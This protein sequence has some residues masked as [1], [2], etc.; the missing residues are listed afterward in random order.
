MCLEL[1]WV[2]DSEWSICSLGQWEMTY[3]KQNCR[4]LPPWLYH[5]GNSR[6]FRQEGLRHGNL[7]EKEMKRLVLILKICVYQ[8][9]VLHRL[10][11]MWWSLGCHWHGHHI[12]MPGKG[13]LTPTY[14]NPDPYL[15]PLLAFAF[16]NRRMELLKVKGSMK[17]ND[18]TSSFDEWVLWRNNHKLTPTRHLL[19][20]GHCSKRFTVDISFSFHNPIIGRCYYY[21]HF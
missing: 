7:D 5:S 10:C 19:S 1:C 8:V 2:C 11:F 15:S 18:P 6:C 14:C 9:W 13:N 20:V 17:M 16:K 3:L 4:Y 21:L 12:F